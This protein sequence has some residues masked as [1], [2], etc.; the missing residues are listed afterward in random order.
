VT[1]A[2]SSYR[3]ERCKGRQRQEKEKI[4]ET[5]LFS[6]DRPIL[7]TYNVNGKGKGG[8]TARQYDDSNVVRFGIPILCVDELAY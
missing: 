2:S 8:P 7:F 5:I 1:K 4:T 3:S 6:K